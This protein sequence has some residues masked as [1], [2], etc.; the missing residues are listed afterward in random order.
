MT[1]RVALSPSDIVYLDENGIAW[2]I[3][4]SSRHTPEK[5]ADEFS[6]VAGTFLLGLGG[7]V[8]W[9]N[10]TL[11][12]KVKLPLTIQLQAAEHS[13]FA[14]CLDING[15]VWKLLKPP[16]HQSTNPTF[17]VEKII[18][19]VKSLT[20]SHN[21]TIVCLMCDKSARIYWNNALHETDIPTFDVVT[22]TYGHDY[23]LLKGLDGRVWGLPCS[24]L[25]VSTHLS[26]GSK[27]VDLRKVH[28]VYWY[29]DCVFILQ[30]DGTIWTS[31]AGATSPAGTTP[32][33]ILQGLSDIIC[34]LCVQHHRHIR[35]AIF[36]ESNGDV[37][38]AP[39]P[40][41]RELTKMNLPKISGMVGRSQFIL[42]NSDNGEVYMYGN[43]VLGN[44]TMNPEKI[45]SIPP[46]HFFGK[47][48]ILRPAAR[49]SFF[50]LQRGN[51]ANAYFIKETFG[52]EPLS[53][54]QI[55]EY[56]YSGLLRVR[57][58]GSE[59]ASDWIAVWEP[60]HR[61]NQE[62]V[63]ALQATKALLLEQKE[64]L[65][66][67]QAVLKDIQSRVESTEQSILA[68]E[69]EW[70]M[71]NFC[72]EL[73]KPVTEVEK[74]MAESFASKRCSKAF[75]VDDVCYYLNIVGIPF[76]V[77]EHIRAK[78]ITGAQLVLLSEISEIATL[79][80]P[81]INC[82][83]LSKLQFYAKLLENDLFFNTQKLTQSV[84]W[85][86][87]TPMKTIQLLKDY[88]IDLNGQILLDKD[89]SISQLIFFRTIDFT[90]I[91]GLNFNESLV[92]V[93]KV[94]KLKLELDNL[95]QNI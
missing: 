21:D 28:S 88:D 54:D 77:I 74:E 81:D 44:F 37:W 67:Q 87:N 85:R 89:L 27:N 93:S 33:A 29:S 36:L 11:L 31:P 39:A 23:F 95:V 15:S 19:G 20:R 13:H 26:L 32:P 64:E 66:K 8:F 83:T 14:I 65:E 51:L 61:K 35:Q 73:V 2:R 57:T 9:N 22:I 90:G 1:L 84:V 7:C 48:K 16:N 43:S 6:V 78:N 18:S 42:F 10:G 34:V 91:F 58:H 55:K 80:F 56:I 45:V 53:K 92:I 79:N 50:D 70:E 62:L 76:E 46:L 60:I 12:K 72:D 30:L 94:K 40:N 69:T 68:Q 86:H 5:V 47:K 24:T 38:F 41:Y 25:R 52:N 49:A 3:S 82:L 4:G 71:Y 75:S 63:N 59:P 17:Q